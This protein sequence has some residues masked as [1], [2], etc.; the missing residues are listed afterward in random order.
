MEPSSKPFDSS[1]PPPARGETP[2]NPWVEKWQSGIDREACFEHIFKQYYSLVFSYFARKGFSAEESRD[3]AQD[4]FLRVYKSLG[5]FRGK[6]R[7]ETWLFQITA[8]LYRNTLR[9][10]STR[11][12]EA[13]EVSLDQVLEPGNGH[14]EL[15]PGTDEA[16]SPLASLVQAERSQV[17]HK[18]LQDL[19]SQMRRCVM[20]RV[21][22]DLKYKDIAALMRISIET[23]K[24]HLFQARKQLKAK[25][26]DY[27]AD[28]DF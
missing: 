21:D 28:P 24:A 8:N 4:T 27:F 20:L 2:G 17:V 12:R 13:S 18:A 15:M 1:V 25:L 14:G 9:A 3:L 7:F 5:T 26:G 22:Y 6:S 16:E 19:P 11:K 10:K 23:V